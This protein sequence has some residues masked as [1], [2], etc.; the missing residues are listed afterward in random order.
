MSDVNDCRP[1]SLSHIVGQ[2]SVKE[3]LQVALDASFND[4]CRMADGVLV[5]GPGLGKSQIAQII[6][7]ELASEF[8]EVLGQSITSLAELNALLLQANGRD[9][10]HIDE[11]HELSQTLQTALYLALDKRLIQCGTGKGI[12][13]I[14]IS[15]FTLLLSTTD[16]YGILQP[17]R[18]RMKLTL[19]F[20]FYSEDELVR[21][22]RY[23][24]K[25]L[26]WQ[27]DESVLLPIA[28]RSR[29]TPRLA[30]RL[31]QSARRVA[32]AEGA[33]VVGSEH[34]IRAAVL[35]QLDEKGL[36]PQEQKYL[37]QLVEGPCRLNVIASCLAVPSRTVAE[38]YEPFLIRSKLV[39]KDNSGRRE[40]TPSGRKHLEE[41]SLF[42]AVML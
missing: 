34:L 4:G 38:V 37:R 11:V 30:L 5:G 12:Q 19:R 22:L 17:L 2:E 7:M 20:E 10:I 36:G 6:S 25:G 13:S 1:T 18:D 15:N 39:C 41:S 40:L 16:E 26:G 23:R 35:E 27:V 29:G 8:H 21:L 31:L 33:D 28:M 3:Q 32:R 9:V 24:I 14:P 42:G